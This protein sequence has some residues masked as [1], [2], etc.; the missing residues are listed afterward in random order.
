MILTALKTFDLKNKDKIS[1]S[2]NIIIQE[3]VNLKAKF[4]YKLLKPK[5]N[6][7]KYFQEHT[8]FFINIPKQEKF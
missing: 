3:Q 2:T 6:N 4:D 7:Y 8:K 5:P 1:I